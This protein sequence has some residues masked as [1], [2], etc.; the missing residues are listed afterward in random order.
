MFV[1]ALNLYYGGQ[2]WGMMNNYGGW[3][4]MGGW[5]GPLLGLVFICWIIVLAVWILSLVNLYYWGMADR[6]MFDK[7]K[8]DKKMWFKLLVLLPIASGIVCLIPIVGWILGFAGFIYWIVINLQ[9]Y[10]VLKPKLM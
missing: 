7:N 2:G 10:F 5:A 1:T 9:F 3:G 4:M 8:E 6:A